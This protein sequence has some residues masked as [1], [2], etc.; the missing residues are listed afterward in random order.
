MS[1][2]PTPLTENARFLPRTPLWQ[3]I[4]ARMRRGARDVGQKVQPNRSRQ[5]SGVQVKTWVKPSLV[6]SLKRR[7]P[8]V[9]Q[10]PVGQVAVRKLF[11][12]PL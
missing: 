12:R 10:L 9:A 8:F 3:A 4:L 5:P 11:L 1:A 6:W 2:L 7:L